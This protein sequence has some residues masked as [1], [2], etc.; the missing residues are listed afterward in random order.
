VFT[1][2]VDVL[3]DGNV[4][5]ATLAAGAIDTAAAPSSST[6]RVAACASSYC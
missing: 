1:T 6:S 3:I 5:T 2:P 4:A